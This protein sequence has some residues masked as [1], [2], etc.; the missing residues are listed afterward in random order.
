MSFLCSYLPSKGTI[1]LKK[2]ALYCMKYGT[3]FPQFEELF[4]L[5][6]ETTK[7]FPSIKIG[8]EQSKRL[9]LR[10]KMRKIFTYKTD[11]GL[12]LNRLYFWGQFHILILFSFQFYTDALGLLVWLRAMPGGPGGKIRQTAH[13]R[14]LVFACSLCCVSS[15]SSCSLLIA[16]NDRSIL[17]KLLWTKLESNKFY[18]KPKS[19]FRLNAIRC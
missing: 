12:K 17:Q 16:V 18:V 10:T 7:V 1:S 14:K 6:L 13:Q 2:C 19:S 8:L 9:K 11:G 3:Y 15:N 4:V 5:T